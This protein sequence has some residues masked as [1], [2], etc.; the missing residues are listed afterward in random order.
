MSPR[1]LLVLGLCS[2]AP[3]GA[4]SIVQPASTQVI[5]Q[6]KTTLKT[7]T[8]KKVEAPTTGKV[9]IVSEGSSRFV[10]FDGSFSTTDQAPDLHVVLEPMATPPQSYKS[11]NGF[12]N[13]G[14]LQKF[15][16]AQ[17][18][19]IPDGI[20][21]KKYKSVSIWCRMANATIGYAPLK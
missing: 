2:L 20:D 14:K 1:A 17:K 9:T 11:L 13:L 19:P 16:G 6:A 5:A 10:E 18:Y 4:L 3:L 7:G 21:L 15:K 12:V 8:F